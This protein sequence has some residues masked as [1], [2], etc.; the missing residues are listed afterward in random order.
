ML[1]DPATSMNQFNI[2]Q[3]HERTFESYIHEAASSLIYDAKDAAQ[4]RDEEEIERL[5]AD[6]RDLLSICNRR[7]YTIGAEGPENILKTLK[8]YGA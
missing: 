3:S 8:T 7:R 5:K 4:S 1:K 6:A 2:G